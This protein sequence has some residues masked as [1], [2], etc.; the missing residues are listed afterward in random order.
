M[1][2][3]E[4]NIL[5]RAWRPLADRCE[6]VAE[7]KTHNRVVAVGLDLVRD[8]LGGV[9]PRPDT[10][11]VGTGTTAVLATD[12]DL[13]TSVFQKVI[14]RRLLEDARITFHMLMETTEGNG[15]TISEVGLF[16]GSTMVNRSIL[17]P[18]I[19]KTSAIFLT[20]AIEIS[21]ANG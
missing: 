17:S 7:S 5:I 1:I 19:A 3:L 2:Q 20:A 4:P 21:L 11:K 12:T 6:L 13:E 14:S 8:L 9:K 16:S 18:T 15:N 10:I